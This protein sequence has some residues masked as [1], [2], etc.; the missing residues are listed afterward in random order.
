VGNAFIV[1]LSSL[2]LNN[3]EPIK[4]PYPENR[5]QFKILRRRFS[6]TAPEAAVFSINNKALFIPNEKGRQLSIKN[7]TS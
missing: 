7:K 5:N 2:L 1:A 3:R 6:S 4:Q